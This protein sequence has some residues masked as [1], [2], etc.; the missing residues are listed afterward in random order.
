[1]CSALVAQVH[2]E[3][4]HVG[5]IMLHQGVDAPSILRGNLLVEL[6]AQL[7]SCDGITLKKPNVQTAPDTIPPNTDD[8]TTLL[9][10]E[11]VNGMIDSSEIMS[12]A[13]IAP[14]VDAVTTEMTAH[15]KED[16]AFDVPAR[17][18]MFETCLIQ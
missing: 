7:G 16:G 17:K 2:K 12:G 18:G 15:I 8:D 11:A 1:M 6:K 5:T 14:G 13:K 3:G 9:L 4:K 10:C